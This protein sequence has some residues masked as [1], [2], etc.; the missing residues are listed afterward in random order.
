MKDDSF[1]SP[2]DMF[3]VQSIEVIEV[4]GVTNAVEMIGTY[5]DNQY[6]DHMLVRAVV[7]PH[8]DRPVGITVV[9]QVSLDVIPI[10]DAAT[11]A[12]TMGA[13]IL[14]SFEFR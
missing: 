4:G 7:I 5:Y 14:S 13:R 8:P 12:A 9:S 6:D 1:P 2:T 11:L 3:L 10:A